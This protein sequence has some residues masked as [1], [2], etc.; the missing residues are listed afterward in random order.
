[1]VVQPGKITQL[2]ED[3]LVNKKGRTNLKSFHNWEGNDAHYALWHGQ[4]LE[5]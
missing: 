2:K 1:M 4:T 3:A 5:K